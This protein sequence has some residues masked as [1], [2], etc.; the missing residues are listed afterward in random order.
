MPISPEQ[1]RAARA[2]LLLEQNDLAQRAE[3]S[4]ITIRRLEA[5]LG[6]S[7]ITP[8]NLEAVRQ[9]LE[10]A[11][12]EFI[13]DGVRRRRVAPPDTHTLYQDLRAISLRSGARLRKQE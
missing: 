1:I 10:N 7:R 11:G 12:A 4:V 13:S 8:A 3:V 5:A 2:L 6:A 9:V